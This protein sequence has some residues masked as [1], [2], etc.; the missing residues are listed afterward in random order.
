MVIIISFVSILVTPAPLDIAHVKFALITNCPTYITQKSQMTSSFKQSIDVIANA[1]TDVINI[2]CSNGL[3][4][5]CGVD[6]SSL[7]TQGQAMGYVKCGVMLIMGTMKSTPL[8]LRTQVAKLQKWTQ[9]GNLTIKL[10]NNVLIKVP[11]I[12]SKFSNTSYVLHKGPLELS[13]TQP[14]PKTVAPIVTNLWPLIYSGIG[15]GSFILLCIV[16]Q[17]LKQSYYLRRKKFTNINSNRINSRKK[18]VDEA[19]ENKDT[20]S[21]GKDN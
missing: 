19:M 14:P 4:P 9:A 13:T 5:F 2:T 10:W 15:M 21:N 1:T 11:F 7:N 12:V 6:T 18:K 17:C 16:Y 8:N 20:A 3:E